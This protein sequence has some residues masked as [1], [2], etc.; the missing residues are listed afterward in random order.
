MGS[1]YILTW[2]HQW[3]LGI[4]G[5]DFGDLDLISKITGD[6]RISNLD[7]NRFVNILSRET[8]DGF[9]FTWVHH[10]GGLF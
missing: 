7:Q 4:K 9:L 3:N 5:L 6:I 2:I 8:I 1:Y 10:W